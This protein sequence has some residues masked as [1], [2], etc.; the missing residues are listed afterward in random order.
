MKATKGEAMSARQAGTTASDLLDRGEELLGVIELDD[1]PRARHLAEDIL[2]G[3]DS[4][5]GD[6]AFVFA[7]TALAYAAWDGGNVADAMLMLRGAVQ[8]AGGTS[9]GTVDVVPQLRLAAALTALGDLTEAD[10]VIDRLEARIDPTGGAVWSAGSLVQRAGVHLAAGRLDA[11]SSDARAVIDRSADPCADLFVPAARSVLA[12]VALHRGDIVAAAGHIGG[13]HAPAARR[14]ATRSGSTAWAAARLAEATGD[15]ARLMIAVDG[16]Y[17]HVARHRRLFVDEPAVAAWLVRVLLGHEDRHRAEVVV[18][19]VEL[20]SVANPGV[21]SLAAAAAHARGVLDG[22]LA[23]LQQ[24]T[25]GHRHPWAMASALEDAGVVLLLRGDRADAR[26]HLDRALEEYRRAGADRDARRVQRR[27]TRS[28]LSRR[29][30]RQVSG[31]DSLTETERRVASVVAEGLTNAEAA[32]RLYLSR[33]T[34]DFHLR[35]IFAKLAIRSRVA[36]VPLV[37]QHVG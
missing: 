23:L 32:E 15:R 11:A 18:L 28:A 19:D 5:P 22:D 16:L 13:Q 33:H 35:H 29:R 1:L 26:D 7:M 3:G 14:S 34:I 21:P 2:T 25:A 4:M 31:W 9:S 20:L 30:T 8:R 17:Q 27:L 12:S 36:L 6:T 37:L 10:E 24:A